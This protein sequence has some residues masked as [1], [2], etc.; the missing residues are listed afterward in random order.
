MQ[1][2]VP[3][4]LNKDTGLFSIIINRRNILLGI[5]ALCSFLLWSNPNSMSVDQKLTTQ[6]A[7]GVV[8]IPFLLD[9]YGRPMHQLMLDA[10]RY[11][12]SKNTQRIALGKDISEGI[13]ITLDGY[14]SKVYRIEP[15]NLTMS[16]EAEVFVFKRYLQSALFALKNQIQII[17]IQ[18][19]AVDDE[20]LQIELNRYSKLSGV[21]QK[22]CEEYIR[23]YGRLNRTM[24]RNY[25]LVI[26]EAA[27]DFESAKRKLLDQENSFVRSLE[28][29]KI[30]L[31]PLS[32]L[33]IK[34]L[35]DQLF[36]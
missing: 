19:Y 22:R 11:F 25:Y 32:S 10:A 9:V 2:I 20:S 34:T 3:P 31:I 26:T 4:K 30:K 16:A 23:E 12:A 24:E 7:I 13:V 8:L 27:R 1:E 5:G 18:Q 15:I 29:T 33:E 21:L 28:Q 36:S 14:Y 35:S 17:T 6:I